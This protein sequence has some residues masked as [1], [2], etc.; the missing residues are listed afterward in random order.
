MPA[1]PRPDPPAHSVRCSVFGTNDVTRWANVFWVRNGGAAVPTEPALLAF[2]TSFLAAYAS[3]FKSLFTSPTLIG[4]CAVL[5]YGPGGSVTGA[6][7][8]NS[9]AGTRAGTA[10]PV[11]VAAC[12]SWKVQQRYR[13]G[14]PRTYLP[15]PAQADVLAANQFQAA[16]KASVVSA[17]NSF[18][19]DVNALTS[20][21]LTD[22]HLGTVSFVLDRAWRSP[23]VFRDFTPG[24]AAFDARIDTQRRRLGRDL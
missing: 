18:N 13:G 24:A 16:Y 6:E 12:I 3:R 8:V 7:F 22:L 21:D 23:P 20:G 11:N 19:G 1:P 5:Y 14:H 4:S 9:T 17:A 15:P 10:L 2:A